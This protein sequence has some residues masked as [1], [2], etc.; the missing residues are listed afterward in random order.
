MKYIMQVSETPGWWVLTDTVNKVVIR[1]EQ[2]K[3]NATQ[4]VT[5]LE[6]CSLSAL[7]VARV[8]REMGDWAVQQHSDK[9]F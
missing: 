9:V 2:H 1:F 5:M 7:Q 4:Q 3:F 8:L 6:D